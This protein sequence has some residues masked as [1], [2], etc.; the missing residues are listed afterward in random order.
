MSIKEK[1][2]NFFQRNHHLLAPLLALLMTYAGVDGYG[3]Y[4]EHQAAQAAGSVQGG[5]VK[6]DV[7]VAG[8]EGPTEL[9]LEKAIQA[10]V[11]AAIAA[12]QASKKY[13]EFD[14]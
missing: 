7:Q 2:Q 10:A 4:Q 5:D 8:S 12:H 13:H 1:N 11:A 9:E 14:G 3:K 6:V